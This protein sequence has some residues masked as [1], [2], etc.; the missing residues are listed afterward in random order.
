REIASYL[1]PNAPLIFVWNVG[2]TDFADSAG[3]EWYRAIRDLQQPMDQ[4]APQYYQGR[5][6]ACFD[7][8]EYDR[9]FEA[10]EMGASEWSV[11]ITEDQVGFDPGRFLQVLPFRPLLMAHG[12]ISSGS[13]H[14]LIPSSRLIHSPPPPNPYISNSLVFAP[15]PR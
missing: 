5:W 8:P 4:G 7:V 3:P 15:A 6:K 12:H 9:Y 11:G 1:R 10:P 2:A 14:T 13:N